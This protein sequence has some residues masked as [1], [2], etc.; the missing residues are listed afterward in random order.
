VAA[1]GTGA[2]QVLCLLDAAGVGITAA[3]GVGGRDLSAEVAGRST[4][5]AL[6]MLDADPATELILLVSKPPAERVAAD[7]R[8]EAAK[9]A[10]PVR[11]A[12][13]G[14]GQPDL[15][16][17]TEQAL[18]ALDVPVPDWPCWPQPTTGL[19]AST[20]R[21]VSAGS[22]RGLFCGGTLCD[23]A[24]LLASAVLGEVRSN[25][26]LRPEWALADPL[27]MAAGHWMVDFGDDALTRGRAHP[28]IDPTLRDRQLRGVLADPGTGVVLADVVLGHG[29]HPDPAAGLLP[30]LQA[31]E[32]PVVIS[33]IGARQDPQDTYATAERLHRAG[34]SVFLSNAA[35]T[36]HALALLGR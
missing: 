27:A 28:M 20:G 30:I 5:T 14:L 34:A 3:L 15:T 25:I 32:L 7:L 36:R 6:A 10:T 29:A 26:P 4:R 21:P 1:S 2:Q 19:P 33:L 17:A 16:A 23:E 13:L 12:L 24:M 22:L 8:A 18:A 9:L 35:A 11:F 31:A